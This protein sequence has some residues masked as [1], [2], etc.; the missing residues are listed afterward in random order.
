MDANE[1]IFNN[2]DL[3]NAVF[4][5]KGLDMLLSWEESGSLVMNYD[6]DRNN[7]KIRVENSEELSQNETHLS[8]SFD[9]NSFANVFKK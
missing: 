3:E 2:M 6:K 4:D 5:E 1:N 9:S 8:H 7:T